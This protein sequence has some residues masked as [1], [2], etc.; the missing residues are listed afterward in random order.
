[1]IFG[2][3]SPRI[4][5]I[6][7]AIK[8]NESIEVF[9]NTIINVN[10]DIRLSQQVHF[11]INQKLTGIYHLGSTDLIYHYDF[12][13]QLIERRYQKRAVFKQV[14][15]S[16]RMRYIAVLAKENK[17]PLNLLFSYTEILNDLTLI[18]KY[19]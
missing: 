12:L 4:L 17:L 11:I 1:M 7:Q 10:S 19:L 18:K 15:T 16:N 2:N 13:K 8:N 3:N 6:E 14:F 5:E 9:P